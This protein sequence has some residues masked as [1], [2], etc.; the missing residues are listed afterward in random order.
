MTTPA[1]KPILCIDFDGVVHSYTSGWKGA[2]QI[3]DPITP[4][5]FEWAAAAAQIFRLTIYSSRSKEGAGIA[6]MRRWLVKQWVEH[7]AM[8]HIEAFADAESTTHIKLKLGAA[9]VFDIYF[10]H[11]KPGAFL[12]LDDRAWC[13]DGTWPD[14]QK[15]L[16]FKTWQEKGKEPVEAY[17]LIEGQPT[18]SVLVRRGEMMPD[19]SI[20]AV[21]IGEFGG[22]RYKD[23][24]ITLAQARTLA[25][26]ITK[27]VGPE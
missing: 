12:T 20:G 8:Y 10:A 27:T 26:Q 15:L 21:F 4:G 16:V 19:G 25:D 23:L 1:Y 18:L 3:P 24:R 6:A 9:E 14:P 2:D 13:F 17:P 5:F 11:E 7:C 22:E